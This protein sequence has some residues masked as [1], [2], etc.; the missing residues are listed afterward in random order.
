MLHETW[1]YD[2]SD[3]CLRFFTLALQALRPPVE[4]SGSLL[5]IGCAEANWLGLAQTAWPEMQLHGIDWRQATRPGDITKGD[6]R[7]AEYAPESFDLIVSVSAIEHIGLGNYNRDPLDDEGDSIA[8]QNAYRWLKPG[9]WIY[10]DVPWD[11]GGGFRIRQPKYR[12]YDDAT[13]Q[14]RL[15][16]DL[17]W[18]EYGRVKAAPPCNS[19]SSVTP[20]RGGFDFYYCGCWWQKPHAEK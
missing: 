14:S 19:L 16:Q 13:L 8:L 4:A 15:N 7:T 12:L 2:G 20:M 11:S 17:G 3:E 18:L 10:F 1:A 6:V 9:G 5:E